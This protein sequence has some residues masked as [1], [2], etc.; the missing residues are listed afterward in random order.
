MIDDVPAAVLL[1]PYFEVNLENPDGINTFFS[2]NN[3]SATPALVHISLFT[4]DGNPI[5]ESFVPLGGY[6]FVT[7]NLRDVFLEDESRDFESVVRGFALASTEE[8]VLWGDYFYVENQR[9]SALG[10][11][12]VPIEMISNGTLET[13]P[14]IFSAR[15][16]HDNEFQTELVIWLGNPAGGIAHITAWNEEDDSEEF[17]L[18]LP[19]TAS[20]VALPGTP[21]SS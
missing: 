17:Y 7:T 12:L 19:A 3:A 4:E 16:A 10:E 2:I 14:H 15:Y 20:R 1:L 9:L 13:L 18:A 8:N 6:N 11:T 21:F 5:F